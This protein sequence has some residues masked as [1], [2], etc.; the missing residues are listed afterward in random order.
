[1]VAIKRTS[2]FLLLVLFV[3]LFTLQAN[4]RRGHS[5]SGAGKSSGHRSSHGRSHST[6]KIG[7]HGTSHYKSS[8]HHS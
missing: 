5:R 7:R 8:F 1:M 2:L 6:A 3:G 4:A